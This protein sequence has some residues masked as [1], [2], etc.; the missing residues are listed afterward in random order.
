M[1]TTARRVVKN[2]GYLYVKMGITMFISLYTTRLILGSLGVDDFGIFNIVGGAISMLGFLN[3]A[4]AGATQ[5]FISYSEGEGDREKQRRI[6]NISFVMHIVIALLVGAV[7]LGAGY[8]FFNGVLNIPSDRVVAAQ[9]VYGSLIV[10]TMFTVATVP[11]DA[12]V[13]AHENM[14]YY[15]IVGIVESV[16]KLLAAL[17]VTR[18]VGD[19]L[20]VYGVLMALVPIITLTIM[21]LYCHK[22]YEECRIAPHRYWDRSLAKEMGIFAGFNLLRSSSSMISQY[23]LSIVLNSFFGVVLN[24]AQGVANQVSGQLMAL[25]NTM[26][27]ALN[28]VIAKSE[29]SGDHRLMQRAT[30]MGS[31]F[32]FLLLALLAIPFMV[33]A[34]Y[35]LK[36]WL[37][38]LP[39][40]AV[41]FCRLQLL[42]SLVEQLTITTGSSIDAKGE[43]KG[44]SIIKSI[45]AIMPIILTFM[46]YEFGL[47]PYSMYIVWIVFG[48]VVGGVVNLYFLKLKCGIGVRTYCR[49]VIAPCLVLSVIPVLLSMLIVGVFEEGFVRLLVSCT[50]TTLSMILSLWFFVLSGDE[51]LIV[52]D[53]IAKVKRRLR[54]KFVRALRRQSFYPFIYRSYWHYRLSNVTKRGDN[55]YYAARPNPGAGIGH[56]MAN[57]IAGYWYAKEFGV[58]FAHLPFS[59]DRWERFMGFGDGEISV[60]TLKKEGYKVR[61][62]PLF[63]DGNAEEFELNRRIID[64]YGSQRVV[65]IAEQDQF[66][67]DQYGVMEEMKRKFYGAKSRVG[68]SLGYSSECFNIALHLRRGDIMNDP[69]NPNLA[70]RYLSNDYFNHV[71]GGVVDSLKSR[72]PIH[73]YIFSQGEVSDYPEFARYE[74]LHWCLDMSA[75]ESLLHMVY[76]DLL[77]TSKSS[78]SYKPALLCNGIKVVPECFWHGYP[79]TSDW[80]LVDNSG[81]FDKSA[82]SKI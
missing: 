69:T 27:K 60:E 62:L 13:N 33:E 43:I 30:M 72:K 21:R 63:D 44:F 36:L 71:L 81:N 9:I 35:I 77:I 3:V 56:Q 76:A 78:F 67:R 26:L 50:V 24:A 45:L 25:S 41:L 64:S 5:R 14:R 47:P 61:V 16:L 8:I 28:P 7:L 42:R 48:G 70:M 49:V 17:V 4:M 74:N 51:R 75:E 23:G 10:S 31:K 37:R 68:Q 15:A 19:R 39:D 58:K 1:S 29:G 32:S 82:L 79:S 2:S 11:Y 65:F 55:I 6:F 22:H 59:T 38:D 40:W 53:M 80:L 20:I 34:S 12:V 52:M 54:A 66:Y 57:W 73:I 18:F 46:L